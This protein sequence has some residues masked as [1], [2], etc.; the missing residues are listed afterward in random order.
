MPLNNY[1]FAMNIAYN[2]IITYMG[3]I[4]NFICRETPLLYTHYSKLLLLIQIVKFIHK[5]ASKLP[6]IGYNFINAT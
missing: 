6:K 3:E 4:T 1:V 5:I 2:M